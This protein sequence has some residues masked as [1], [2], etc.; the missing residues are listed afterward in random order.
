MDDVFPHSLDAIRDGLL[1]LDTYQEICDVDHF[2][3]R[4]PDFNEIPEMLAIASQLQDVVYS[5]IG[6]VIHE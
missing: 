6:E 3:I 2:N 5:Q 1:N 4:P